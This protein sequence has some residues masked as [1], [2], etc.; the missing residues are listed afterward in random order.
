MCRKTLLQTGPSCYYVF[1]KHALYN[2]LLSTVLYFILWKTRRKSSSNQTW[3]ILHIISIKIV[4][5][6]SPDR[7]SWSGATLITPVTADLTPNLGNVVFVFVVGKVKL[8]V[9]ESTYTFH[10]LFYFHHHLRREKQGFL[11][12]WC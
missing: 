8:R 7:N 3:I 2:S 4:G 11:T 12:F 9:F 10:N 6:S 5:K 1:R